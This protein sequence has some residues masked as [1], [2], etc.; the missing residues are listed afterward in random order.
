MEC[1]KTKSSPPAAKEQTH[2]LMLILHSIKFPHPNADAPN[3][4]AALHSSS[5]PSTFL[6]PQWPHFTPFSTIEM[7]IKIHIKIQI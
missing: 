1:C 7:G 5:S 2:Q 3:P 6:I 4:P